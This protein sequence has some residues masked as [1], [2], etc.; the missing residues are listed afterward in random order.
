[1]ARYVHLKNIEDIQKEKKR[2]EMEIEK[3]LNENQ[4][5]SNVGDIVDIYQYGQMVN[6]LDTMILGNDEK[7]AD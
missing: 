6:E 3:I 2:V 5:R 7:T 4:F 1:M